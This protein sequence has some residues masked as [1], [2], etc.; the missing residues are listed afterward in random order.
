MTKRQRNS[1]AKVKRARHKRERNI[2]DVDV[3]VRSC[4]DGKWIDVA[5]N[6]V[7]TLDRLLNRNMFDMERPSAHAASAVSF[8]PPPAGVVAEYP[9]PYL[10]PPLKFV[11]VKGR[12][13]YKSA[14]EVA[15]DARR[16]TQRLKD[17]TNGI[18]QA[19][20]Y[21]DLYRPGQFRQVLASAFRIGDGDAVAIDAAEIAT[22]RRG[23]AF[24]KALEN[25]LVM[26]APG[27]R[28]AATEC[29]IYDL[30]GAYADAIQRK[31]NGKA[32]KK[33]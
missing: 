25:A 1:K 20:A 5:C 14:K 30:L 11:M 19:I 22:M 24:H 17:M 15:R 9:L 6:T 16:H 7:V 10:P 13:H 4:G 33:K 29:T 2:L 28:F 21:V 26:D 12:K 23:T 3:E 8:Q 27:A 32:R 31:Q 18:E